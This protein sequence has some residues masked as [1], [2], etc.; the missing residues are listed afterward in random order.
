MVTLKKIVLAGF[1]FLL[2]I[3][4]AL[5]DQELNLY[6]ETCQVFNTI[7]VTAVGIGY[8][9]NAYGNPSCA[10]SA[11]RSGNGC[12]YPY[13]QFTT[14]NKNCTFTTTYAPVSNIVVAGTCG[15]ILTS[16]L[17]YVYDSGVASI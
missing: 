11:R 13:V 8:W 3:P 1:T 5:A 17:F 7:P 12:S 6:D 16:P 15:T 2:V 10:D 14:R 9:H 4:M